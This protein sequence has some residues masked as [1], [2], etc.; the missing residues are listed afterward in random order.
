MGRSVTGIADEPVLQPSP[1]QPA[2]VEPEL[3]AAVNV[4][5]VPGEYDPMQ[6]LPQFIFPSSYIIKRV[7][8]RH[9]VASE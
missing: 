9:H 6:A 8:P 5:P 4:T 7:C 2:N 1:D 3:T